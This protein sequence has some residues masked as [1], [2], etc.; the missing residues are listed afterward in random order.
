M[1]KRDFF[2][3]IIK[4]F[5]LYSLILTIFNWIPSNIIYTV[6][7]FEALP[8]LGLL[9][10]TL[11]ALL[12]YY[13]LIKKTDF[14]IDFIKLDKGFDDQTMELGNLK[15]DHILKLGIILVG[16]LFVISNLSDFLQYAFLAFKGSIQ[17]GGAFNEV[18]NERFGTSQD[19][20]NWIFSGINLIIGYL[21]LTNYS[22]VI[23]WLNRNQTN[24][25]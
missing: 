9:G 3:I 18:F 17:K 24:K 6:F 15:P 22:T 16:G 7:D 2:R 12:I 25:K 13:L 11:L 20:F 14:I 23:K 1:T 8:I 21:L 19:N 10:F 5:A 4:I